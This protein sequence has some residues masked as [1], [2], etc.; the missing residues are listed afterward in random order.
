MNFQEK[1]T[2]ELYNA[3][4]IIL[5]DLFNNNEHYYYVTLTTDG[6]ANTPCISAW[7][8]EALHRSSNDEQEQ[9]EIKWSYADSPYCCWKQEEF[10]KVKALLLS[11]E[12]IWD[13]DSEAFDTEYNLR[14]EAMEAAMKRLDQEGMFDVNQERADVIVLV[15]VMPPDYTNTERAYR[16]NCE[17]YEIFSKWLEEAAER[18]EDYM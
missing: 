10:E 9:E 15:E 13:L 11:R 6:G 4:K 7:S 2:Q 18:H 3:A 14:F 1:L 8:Y 12:N 17:K 16:M 5:R